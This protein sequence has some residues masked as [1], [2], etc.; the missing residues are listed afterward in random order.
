MGYAEEI[1]KKN[2]EISLLG[3]GSSYPLSNYFKLD[4]NK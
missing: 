1:A 4:I 3:L 2:G